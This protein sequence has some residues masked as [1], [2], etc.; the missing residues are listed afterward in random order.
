MW[1]AEIGGKRFDW[2]SRT[3]VM[4]IVNV[5]P[6]S[7]SG[8]GLGTDVEAAVAQGLR[9][10][11]EGADMLDVGGES[12]RPGHIAIGAGEEIRRTETVV[13]R[14]AAESGIPISID[15]YK[16]EVAAQAIA[17]GATILND[18]WGLTR[19]PGIADLAARHDCA[20]VLMHNQEGTDYAGDL[21]DEIKRFLSEAAARAVAA[22]IP[23]EKVIVDPGIGFGKTAE[24][25][26]IVMRRLEELK[27][28]GHPILL[29]TSRKSFIGKLLDL[30]VS[31]RLEGTE[32]TV[33]AG[34][35]RGADI[36]RVHDVLPTTRA[37]RVADR[38]K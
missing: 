7:F 31:D 29:G 17:R 21:M 32:A 38:M 37:V 23:R 8:D 4:G 6:D 19:S 15:T 27:D 26:W 9:M 30:P 14:L 3:Y 25:N 35:L 18:V 13:R 24:H 2:G 1:S 5:T 20:L 22:G 34:V 33:V 36:V 11:G 28:L 12:T 16:E 10:A